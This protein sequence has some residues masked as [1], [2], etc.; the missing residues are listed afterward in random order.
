MCIDVNTSTSSIDIRRALLGTEAACRIVARLLDSLE[1]RA[2]F[3]SCLFTARQTRQHHIPG[4]SDERVRVRFA[5]GALQAYCERLRA[6]SFE[7]VLDDSAEAAEAV[8]GASARLHMRDTLRQLHSAT[9]FHGLRRQSSGFGAR[10]GAIA[11]RHSAR[12]W[13]KRARVLSPP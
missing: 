4:A 11:K 13:A 12:I 8:D 9:M 5:G 10:F 1:S 6:R 2:R 3:G 7:L